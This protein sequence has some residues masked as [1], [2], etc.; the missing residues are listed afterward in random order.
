M[1][2]SFPIDL[3]LSLSFFG[4]AIWW[5]CNLVLDVAGCG[6]WSFPIWFKPKPGQIPAST[7]YVFPL[8]ALDMLFLFKFQDVFFL[9]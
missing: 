3:F 4:S 8:S 6:G 9:T 1:R 2:C 5:S 7:S